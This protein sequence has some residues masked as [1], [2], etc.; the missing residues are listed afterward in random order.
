M[1]PAA[2]A[3][4]EA[5]DTRLPPYLTDLASATAGGLGRQPLGLYLVGSLAMDDARPGQSDLD[6]L[7]IL[8]GPLDDRRRWGLAARVVPVGLACPWAGIEYVAYATD[9]VRVPGYPLRYELNVNAGPRRGLLVSAGGD[10]AHWFLLDVAMA[11][12]HALPLVGPPARDLIGAADRSLVLA[13]LRDALAW[14]RGRDAASPNAVLNACRTWHYLETG[15]WASKTAAGA[16]ALALADDRDVVA[17]ALGARAAG[18]LDGLEPVRVAAFVDAI[19]ARVA[20][21]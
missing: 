16:W 7:A 5:V 1:H 6:V 8:D 11:R 19:A 21:A 13:A 12:E 18:R 4:A 9:A 2:L 15:A 14:H 10:P 17:A 20:A 3:F